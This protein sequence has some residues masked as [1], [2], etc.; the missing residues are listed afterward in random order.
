VVESL[1]N[2][3]PSPTLEAPLQGQR[4][5]PQ[6]QQQQMTQDQ[7]QQVP[8]PTPGTKEET[9]PSGEK[10]Q[11]RWYKEG[12]VLRYEVQVFDKGGARILHGYEKDREFV[13]VTNKPGSPGQTIA[14]YD[15]V[16]QDGTWGEWKDGK[17]VA[18]EGQELRS[19]TTTFGD[20]RTVEGVLRQDGKWVE[21]TTNSNEFQK[22][23]EVFDKV[24]GKLLSR[25][26]T[27][28]D[29]KVNGEQRADGKWV[30]TTT[31]STAFKNQIEVF[32]RLGGTRLSLDRLENDG[33]KVHGELRDGKWVET[34]TGQPASGPVR[35]N[36]DGTVTVITNDGEKYYRREGDGWKLF[37][38]NHTLDRQDGFGP[39][40]V[41]ESWGEN[42]TYTMNIWYK[43]EH[44]PV[45]SRDHEYQ[46]VIKG[47]RATVTEYHMNGAWVY[48]SG[49]HLAESIDAERRW[50][51]SLDANGNIKELLE[52]KCEDDIKVRGGWEYGAHWNKN[53]GWFEWQFNWWR[54]GP[55]TPPGPLTDYWTEGLNPHGETVAVPPG[56]TIEGESKGGKWV[57]TIW[58]ADRSQSITYVY[59]GQ[60]KKELIAQTYGEQKGGKWVETTTNCK[61]FITRTQVF[62]RVGGNLISQTT[63]RKVDDMREPVTFQGQWKDGKWV[64]TAAHY[65][66]F[67]SV[68]VEYDQPNGQAIRRYGELE[69]GRRGEDTFQDGKVQ[70]RVVKY[71]EQ[72]V[73]IEETYTHTQGGF[74]IE[75][76]F[77]YPTG[78][79]APRITRDVTKFKRVGANGYEFYDYECH[80]DKPV[81]YYDD[82]GTERKSYR[83]H[84][85]MI[86]DKSGIHYRESY[87]GTPEESI[88]REPRPDY[89]QDIHKIPNE[90]RSWDAI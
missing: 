28:R 73:Q 16:G 39:R 76:K 81:T 34:R 45:G 59:N 42:G 9:T 47:D 68:T 65:L 58:N 80:Y 17:W 71:E 62:D 37:A 66:G 31:D 61:D 77:T 78:S 70:T 38:Y 19:R 56:V 51:Y 49:G 8:A 25:E 44:G 63:V 69:N 84:W 83:Y 60:D 90:D 11:H 35:P 67:K 13:V 5:Q 2:A 41:E 6:Y 52:Y 40:W 75:R 27:F 57:E 88:L 12:D 1:K 33:V 53:A 15:R 55:Y 10:I 24:D 87:G 26:T 30:E 21:T 36:R 54:G 86:E 22:R 20:G 32:D 14:R 79:D 74:Q 50:T 43:K 48:G 23:V 46:I 7:K 3:A 72:G 4:Q 64:E 29:R 18:A 85:W 82:K 89:G